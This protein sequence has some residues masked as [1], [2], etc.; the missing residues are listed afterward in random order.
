MTNSPDTI[1]VGGRAFTA[2]WESSRAVSVAVSGGVIAAIGDDDDI[3]ELADAST[4]EVEL[5]GGLLIPGFHDAHAHPVSG[6]IELLQCDLSG[7]RDAGDCLRIIGEYAAANPGEEWLVG[8]GWSMAYFPGGTPLASALDAVVG[9]RPAVFLNRDHHGAWVSSEAMRRAE[10]TRSTPDPADG[11]IEHD[12][13]GEPTGTLHEG[14]MGLVDR[15]RPPTDPELAYRGLLRAQEEYFRQGIVG[16]QDAWVGRT[17]GLD[18]LLATYLDALDRSDLRARVSAALWWERGDGL[19]QLPSLIERRERVRARGRAEIL[20]AETVKI[21]V[22]GVAE[23]FTAAMS[24]PYLDARGHPTGNSG[25]TFIE[26]GELSEFVVALDAAGFNVHFHALGDRAVTVSLDALEAAQRANGVLPSRHHLAHLQVVGER[27]VPR[28]AEL[29]AT[30]NLQMLWAT[31][32]DQLRDLTFPHLE[33]GLVPRHYPFGELLRAGTNLAAGSDWPVSTADPIAAIHVGVNRVSPLEDT[34]PLGFP[35]QALPLA[36]AMAA[37]TAGSA[38]INGRGSYSGQ[39]QVG[40]R[41]DLAVLAVDPFAA[42]AAAIATA[43]VV[44]TWIDGKRVFG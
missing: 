16:W 6:G 15:V 43:S 24:A 10:I 14:A 40:Y 19:A 22:D 1:F 44:S 37:Y 21:M 33:P 9:N 5:E 20:D 3:R 31:I 8:G 23:N 30:A 38:G 4:N 11:R 2:G 17:F 32:D 26:P 29:G 7:A 34:S 42:E 27:D 13:G 36:A 35:E 28:F 41:A 39:L 18:D 12:A 25:L